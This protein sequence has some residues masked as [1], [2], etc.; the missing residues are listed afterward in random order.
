MQYSWHKAREYYLQAKQLKG[1]DKNTNHALKNIAKK[2]KDFSCLR[3]CKEQIRTYSEDLFMAQRFITNGEFERALQI[4][5]SLIKDNCSIF[6][7]YKLRG[8]CQ[9]YISN[10]YCPVKIAGLD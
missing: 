4:Y 10:H 8:I 9:F 1:N 5:N 3:K 2:I 6:T 7:F